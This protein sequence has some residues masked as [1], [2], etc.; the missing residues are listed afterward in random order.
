[1]PFSV[2]SACE[3][4]LTGAVLVVDPTTIVPFAEMPSDFLAAA[5]DEQRT[6]ARQ[7]LERF[8]S[9]AQEAGIA[10]DTEVPEAAV[11]AGGQTLGAFARYF[12]LTI[13][14]Q[15]NPDVPTERE[16]AIEAALFA[17]G[18]PVLVVPYVHKAP[19]Q[20]EQV[21]IAWDGSATAARALGDALPLLAR[22]KNIQV[23]SAVDGKEG[24][25]GPRIVRHLEQ[26]AITAKFHS[27]PGADDPTDALLSYAAD[28]CAD[29]LVMGGY[30]HSRFRELLLGGTTRGILGSMI[31]PVFISH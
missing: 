3:A 2:T 11:N 28:C 30:G 10:V 20:L 22:A 9:T 31:L 14:E 13:I 24:P 17:S 16:S 26:H 8:A 21:L 15:P 4:H 12:D 23:V 27:L 6:D 25:F 19:L 18:R 5:L 29:L 1:M 7:I